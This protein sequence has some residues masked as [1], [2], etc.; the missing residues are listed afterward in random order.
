M[1]EVEVI[2]GPLL[3]PD[4]QIDPPVCVR[5]KLAA[6]TEPTGYRSLILPE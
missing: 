5:P 1:C 4:C 2:A 6:D 3:E